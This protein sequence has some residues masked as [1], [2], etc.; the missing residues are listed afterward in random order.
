MSSPVIK[1]GILYV[2]G[3]KPSVFFAIDLEK[4]AIKWKKTLKDVLTGLDDVP[5]VIS[6]DDIVY[7]TGIEKT[8][9]PV[10]MR[11]T[12]NQN[13]V[14]ATY[15]QGDK[16]TIGKLIGK[17]PSM[18]YNHKLYGFNAENG[19]IE[20]EKSLRE[21][22][23]IPNNKSGAPMIYKGTV[24]VGSPITKSFYAFDASNGNKLW[25]FETNINKAPPVADNNIVYFT[26]TKGLVYGFDTR[27]GE[28]LGRKLLGGKLSPSGPLLV[29][30]RL[31]I[32]SQDKNVY[33]EKIDDILKSNDKISS[34]N[35]GKSVFSYIIL[36]YI[37]PILIL[38]LALFTLLIWK[39]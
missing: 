21:G 10:S 13:E 31:I 28:L 25:D 9:Q 38:I 5:P 27:S 6:D 19:D 36:I 37:I 3:T 23:M 14:L 22:P 17:D 18:L 30:D 34:N 2:G 29:N 1:D 15:K 12:Y 32:G 26:D 7:T 4:K 11:E 24:F 16:I 20:W 33:I 8:N 35:N 39:I